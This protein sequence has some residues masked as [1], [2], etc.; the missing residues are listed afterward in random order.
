M[1]AVTES[2]H[3]RV[4]TVVIEVSLRVMSQTKEK[5]AVILPAFFSPYV[6]R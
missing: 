5:R 4:I 3:T 6:G 2:H 1:F